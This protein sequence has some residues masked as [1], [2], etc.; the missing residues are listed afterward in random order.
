MSALDDIDKRM[1]GHVVKY[2]GR[3]ISATI[4]PFLDQKSESV[5]RSRIRQLARLG[6]IRLQKDKHQTLIFPVENAEAVVD[7]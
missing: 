5:L 3:N 4:E 7:V 1:R 2:P 6:L